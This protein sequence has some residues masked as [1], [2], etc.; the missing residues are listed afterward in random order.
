M[1][2]ARRNL[3]VF[4]VV[5]SLAVVAVT[6]GFAISYAD[7]GGWPEFGRTV[8]AGVVGVV[9]GRVILKRSRRASR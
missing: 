9:V 6:I 1:D 5:I 4:I 7:S 3:I 2:A 8:L